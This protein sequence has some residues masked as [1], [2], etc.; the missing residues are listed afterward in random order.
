MHRYSVLFRYCAPPPPFPS[1]IGVK[2]GM[3]GGP[4]GKRRESLPT[5]NDKEN[6]PRTGG[7][8][9]ENHFEASLSLV[10]NGRYGSILLDDGE[11][12]DDAFRDDDELGKQ[13]SCLPVTDTNCTGPTR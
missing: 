6:I 7:E 1:I 2:H 3:T 13:S 5:D 8:G 4:R 12:E 10:I 9:A 11:K